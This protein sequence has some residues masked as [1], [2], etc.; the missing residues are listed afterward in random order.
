L[1]LFD[2]GPLQSSKL[3]SQLLYNDRCTVRDAVLWRLEEPRQ[4]GKTVRFGGF[5]RLGMKAIVASPKMSQR[6]GRVRSVKPACQ[7]R[8]GIM[9]RV[10]R[11]A[12]RRLSVSLGR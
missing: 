1:R 8:D 4:E 12:V 5:Y 10:A 6:S 2:V 3:A 11:T 9:I 7:R